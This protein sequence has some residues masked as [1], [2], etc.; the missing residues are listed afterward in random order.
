MSAAEPQTEDEWYEESKS[1]LQ[2]LGVRNPTVGESGS[3]PVS[4]I[5]EKEV[6]SV[7]ITESTGP[8]R[9]VLNQ[10]PRDPEERLLIGGPKILDNYGSTVC[11]VV[12]CGGILPLRECSYVETTW[13]EPQI[14]PSSLPD[15]IPNTTAY[16]NP[17][18]ARIT[19][20]VEYELGN[21]SEP[22]K[23]HTQK[24]YKCKDNGPKDT[25]VR[26][27]SAVLDSNSD[28]QFRDA[29]AD[30]TLENVQHAA[31]DIGPDSSAT[32]EVEWRK[33]GALST[34]E[35][36]VDAWTQGYMSAEAEG[37]LTVEYE[38]RGSTKTKEFDVS[39]E[40]RIPVTNINYSW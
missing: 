10:F 5:S 30:E 27:E 31:S 2:R 17:F 8:G 14:N 15:R 18:N 1:M 23:K 35:S 9:R 19:G 24:I 11:N 33:D 6:V 13:T 40:V 39:S 29:D 7:Q 32:V 34:L 25:E 36:L 28:T 38:W 20:D 16:L 21:D 26:E 3:I 37:S 12:P 4:P 22:G